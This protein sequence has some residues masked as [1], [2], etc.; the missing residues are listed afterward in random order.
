MTDQTPESGGPLLSFEKVPTPS[1][2]ERAP[3]RDPAA[4]Q[5]AANLA[6]ETTPRAPAAPP[7]PTAAA[8]ATRAL[9]ADALAGTS[10]PGPK[11]HTFEAVPASVPK[12]VE[13]P[14]KPDA[15][16]AVPASAAPA[17]VAQQRMSTA[18]MTF[19]PSAAEVTAASAVSAPS[20]PGG[21]GWNIRSHDE[22]SSLRGK[23][24]PVAPA[25]SPRT[26][27]AMTKDRSAWDVPAEPRSRR[28]SGRAM[29]GILLSVVLVAILGFAGFEYFAGKAQP[30]VTIKKP[31]SVGT[32]T[33]ISTP[34]ALA[35]SQQMQKVMLAY[36]A[37]SV[38]S[39]VYGASGHPTLVVVLAQG[40]NLGA[41]SNEFF[42]DFSTGLQM[43]GVTVDKS[44]TV[45]TTKS[46]SQFIC[47]PATRP[48]PQTAVSLCGWEDGG[49]IGLVMDVSGQPVNTTL[50]EAV[51]AK[52]A[53][54][55]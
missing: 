7:P 20:V 15:F 32:L 36:G 40:P 18:T 43:D 34:A 53:G 17:G 42:N 3:E 54:E 47:S 5:A 31:V 55:H 33:P 12:P 35:V 29:V 41:T 50:T 51:Q 1:R 14:S 38:V 22:E 24:E 25:W 26:T 8:A 52:S 48:A 44:K 27:P 6:F 37:T 19:R 2:S 46:G 21:K 9:I 10:D 49:T 45:K 13:P 4:D 11:P 39:G 16:E 30:A 28:P 23:A